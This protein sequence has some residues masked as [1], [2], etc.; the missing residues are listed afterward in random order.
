MERADLE[1]W[2]AREVARLLSL[3]ESER[4]YYQEIA[5]A[6]PV[7]LLVVS[8]D[9]GIVSANRAVRKIFGLSKSPL[10]A[11]LDTL[12]PPAVAAR[13]PEVLDTAIPQTGI[14]VAEPK[15]GHPLRV[16][17]LAIRAWDDESGPEAL[18]SV[19]DLSDGGSVGVPVPAGAGTGPQSRERRLL[20]EQWVQAERVQAAQKLAARLAHD[21]NNM[22]MIA[23]GHAEE[24]LA[25]L[26][27]NSPLRADIQEIVNANER[28]TALT[29]H[30]LAFTR[31]QT[32]P[33]GTVD[34]AE[35][36][37]GLPERAGI[38]IRPPAAP[39]VVK[40]NEDLLE[41]ALLALM[42]GEVQLRIEASRATIAEDLAQSAA[43]LRPG[44][45]GMVSLSTSRR[46]EEGAKHGWFEAALP[47]KGAADDF[48]GRVTR[49]YGIIRQ[50]GGDIA[51]AAEPG[52]G[53]LLQIFLEAVTQSAGVQLEPAAGTGQTILV[54]D[55]EPRIRALVQKILSRH[56]YQVLEAADGQE[57]L[58]MFREHP[59]INLL[60]TDVMMPRMGGAE[61][62]DQL[63]RQRIGVKVLYVS[64]Y[65]EDP[66][67]LAGKFP[68]GTA[69]LAKPFT[70]AALMGKVREV[71]EARD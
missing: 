45:Y 41:Q 54:V 16:S 30:L 37:R 21:L 46:M 33:A 22:L 62:V 31:K 24:A 58:T 29:A 13:V 67:I 17:I 4:R 36:L 7:G 10:R 23:S 27:A 44:K 39:I 25:G 8:R 50:W 38:E 57:A 42:E 19:E 12:L 69:F 2:K 15:S 14:S 53:T 47:T 61:L 63:R 40:A 5:S 56:G 64:G 28:M 68:P 35:V 70:I 49:T 55:D 60:I 32:A 48:A 11:S 52:G 66:K 26:P 71:L 9:L 34:L 43:P 6:V 20:E 3:V 51:V 18:I 59:E 1:Q 65:T